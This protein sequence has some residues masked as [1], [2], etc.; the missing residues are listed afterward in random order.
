[1]SSTTSNCREGHTDPA[2]TAAEPACY[3]FDFGP[4]RPRITWRQ[5][6]ARRLSNSLCRSAAGDDLPDDLFAAL[7]YVLRDRPALDSGS[8]SWCERLLVRVGLPLPPRDRPEP[9]PLPPQDAARITACF[10]R[11]TRLL[12]QI[13]PYRTGDY[14]TQ[15]IA[16]LCELEEERPAETDVFGYLRR[17]AVAI[18]ALLD[19]MGDDG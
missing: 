13:A 14:P 17:Y 9:A 19:L 11:V 18:V 8:P 16:R 3:V 2:A 5:V 4:E 6:A 10:R 12:V 1:M 7:D 15:Q